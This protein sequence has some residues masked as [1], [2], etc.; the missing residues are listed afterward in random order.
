VIST[1]APFD[2]WIAGDEQAIGE[3]AKR[4]F[5]LFNTKGN[6][7]S[8]HTGWNLTDHGFHDI[9]LP[10]DDIGRGKFLP[11]QSMKHAFKT[12][13]L[14]DLTRRAPYMHDGSL[15]DLNAV[16]EHYDKGGVMRPSLSAEM[17]PLHLTAGEKNDLVA[18]MLTLTGDAEPVPMPMLAMPAQKPGF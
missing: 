15:P 16:M 3:S 1:S 4:G 18:F 2:R 14:R 13:T 17:K 12:P 8:C 10:D 9:G 7:A 6:C 5:E 11:L